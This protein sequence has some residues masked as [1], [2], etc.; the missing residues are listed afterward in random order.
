MSMAQDRPKIY[1]RTPRPP[2]Y[3]TRHARLGEDVSRLIE[4]LDQPQDL[5]AFKDR[6]DATDRKMDRL[7]AVCD[8]ILSELQAHA[9]T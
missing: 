5:Q 2:T 1:D 8:Q 3:A 4:S 7:Q 6:L 9:K